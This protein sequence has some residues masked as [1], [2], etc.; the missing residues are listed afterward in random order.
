[1]CFVVL[2]VEQTQVPVLSLDLFDPSDAGNDLDPPA[3]ERLGHSFRHR[4]IFG[5]QDARRDF[6]QRHPRAERRE[7]RG[8]LA[9]RRGGAYHGD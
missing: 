7:H 2:C 5:C 1:V 3:F 8:Q 9:S 4:L 6:Q